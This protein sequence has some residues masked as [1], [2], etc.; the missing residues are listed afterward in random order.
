[1][2]HG[3]R[4]VVPFREVTLESLAQVGGKNASLGEMIGALVPRG[5][6]VPDGFAVTAEAFRAHLRDGGIEKQVYAELDGLDPEDVG[7][8]AAAGHR[9]RQL[10]RSVPL[11]A[12]VAAQQVAVLPA[13]CG[14]DHGVVSA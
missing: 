14:P 12:G 1:M 8:L 10:V 3:R 11:P 13:S 5:I 9:I 4:W 2:T 6:R 7:A